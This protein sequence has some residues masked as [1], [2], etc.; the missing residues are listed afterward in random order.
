[1]TRGRRAGAALAILVA[2]PLAGT[3]AAAPSG[4]FDFDTTPGRLSR[5]VVPLRQLIALN[6]DPEREPFDGRVEIQLRVRRPQAAIELHAHTLQA[7]EA[8]LR[9]GPG[10]RGA[11][12][13]L[14]VVP[15]TEAQ[16]WR[17][18]PVDGLPIAAGT[19]RVDIRYGGNVR[20]Q[21][22]GLFAARARIQGQNQPMLATQLQ[23]I[24]ARTV[25]PVFDEPAFRTRFELQVRAPAAYEVLSNMPGRAGAA[26]D[27]SRTHVFA[28]TPPMPSYL[29]AVAVGRFEMLHGQAAGVP[30]RIVTAP[31]KSEHGRFALQATERL[32]P[33]FTRYFGVPYSLPRL[34]QLAVPSTRRGAMEDWGLI[35]YIE[36]GLLVDPERSGPAHRRGVF[37]LIAHEVSHQWFG[38]LVTAATWNEIW[39]N[40]AFANWME[41]KVSHHFHPE[42]QLPLNTR[43]RVDFTMATDSTDATRAIRSGPVR[44]TQVP[45]VFDNITY[46]K[47]GAVLGMIEQWL[48]EERLRRG[49]AAYVRERRLSNATAADLWHHVGRAAGRDVA[50]MAASWTDQPGFPLVSVALRC[51]GG[52]TVVELA[53]QRFRAVG[54]QSA[55]DGGARWQVPVRLARGAQNRTVMLDGASTRTTLPGCN[56]QPLVVNAGGAGYYR[57]AYSDA[58]RAALLSTLPALPEADR[59]ALLADTLALAQSGHLPLAQALVALRAVDGVRDGARPALLRRAAAALGDVDAA[60]AGS[61]AR[62][63]WREA[64]IALLAPELQRLGWQPAAGEDEATLE[65]RAQLVRRLAA[66]DHAPTLA[67]ALDL[68]RREAAG[69]QALHPSLRDAVTIASAMGADETHFRQL[70]ARLLAAPNEQER[71]LLSSALAS[72]RDA[73]RAAELLDRLLWSELP[74]STVTAVPRLMAELSPHGD[75]AYRHLL[76]HWPRWEALAGSVGRRGL[77]P[78][79][80]GGSND[81]E[82][83]QA[84]RADQARLVGPDGATLAA[85]AAARIEQRA[86]LRSRAD[87]LAP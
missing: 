61:P 59:M 35:S 20:R 24:F 37:G 2:L 10:G 30:L 72:G 65:L 15:D 1:M 63:T 43:A 78:G 32:L 49:L 5:D 4:R 83:A 41:T 87:S 84:L 85:R 13:A 75:L 21:G 77:L 60:L 22:L 69:A 76:D 29:V 79:A 39:L 33:Y 82:R 27:G 42:W 25:F 6:L 9:P 50:A 67:Q 54:E 14:K 44:E 19:H 73:G 40:E 28:P 71:W 55:A 62:A 58:H 86:A 56:D 16:V 52:A 66:L 3:A 7:T 8:T 57:V 45:D 36:S 18:E 74:T 38:N 46:V 64:A 11:A 68:A 31:G 80:A 70:L 23:S 17:L 53:Q 47:G 26:S 12:R 81:R 51:E 48:G 34:D